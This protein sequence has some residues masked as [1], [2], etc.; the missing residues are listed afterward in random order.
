MA[1]GMAITS[2]EG[3]LYNA[4]ITWLLVF[5][6]AIAS[7]GGL[8]FGYDIGTSGGVTSMDH[9]LK[10][11]FPDVYKKMKEDSMTS[12]YCKFDSQLLTS[13][14]SSLYIAGLVASLCASPVTRAFGRKSSILLAGAS[15]LAGSAIGGAAYNVFML[16][17]ARVL[18][19]VG[20]GFANQSVPMYLS[21]MA[22]P[23]SRGAFGIGFDL[24]IAIGVLL[25]NLVNYGAEKV[26]GGWGWRVSLA[27]AGAPASFLIVGALF[28]PET[29]NSLIEDDKNHEKAKR[30]LQQVRGVDDVQIELDDLIRAS[31]VS[32]ITKHPFK[33][34]IKRKYR[35]QLVMSIAIPFFQQ[36]TGINVITFYAP[37]LF[38]TIGLGES[39]SLMSAVVTGAVVSTTIF[40]TLLIADKVG[41][42]V[43]FMVGGAVMLVCQFLIGGIMAIKLGDHGRL[44]NSYGILVLILVCTYVAGFGLS[45]GPLGWLVPSEISPLEIRSTALSIRVAVDFLLL[46]L[47][48]QA[49]L[50]MLCHFKAG[51]FFFFGGWVALMTAFVYLLLP[52]TKNV[53][54]ERMDRI[55]REHW[56][57][58]RFV[59]DDD[60]D[61]LGTKAEAA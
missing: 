17:L 19:G 5:S 29:P 45:W 39:A 59:L 37:I 14:T 36:L 26:K 12:N 44:S 20:I 41:R 60:E 51:I 40:F 34:I 49:F 61:S 6:C 53:P 25:A 50:A 55:W 23:K 1:A 18:L 11:F 24:C 7:T 38:R 21:E 15:F 16:M 52:E 30:V 42:R 28:L 31:N 47:V 56:F 3:Q 10:K 54:L 57:W 2:E 33:H 58:R 43:L 32:K 8:I 22:P 13:F 4:R 27:L 9:F 48:A 35:P 46:F